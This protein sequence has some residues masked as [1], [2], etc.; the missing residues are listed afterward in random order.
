M[1]LETIFKIHNIPVV[2]EYRFHQKRRWRFDF[3]IPQ[4]KIAIEYEGGVYSK[5]RHVRGRGYSNDCEKYNAAQ[6]MGW[7]V[8]RYTSEMVKNNPSQIIAQ[9]NGLVGGA[10]SDF[11]VKP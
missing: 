6:V 1:N 3:A 9:V 4:Y 5:G 10:L 2:K 8:L 7:R 11:G